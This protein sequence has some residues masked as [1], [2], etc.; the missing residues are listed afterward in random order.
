LKIATVVV[1]GSLL[2]STFAAASLTVTPGLTV[3]NACNK[4]IVIAV[5]YRDSRRNWTTASFTSIRAR[6]QKDRVV[7]SDNSVFYYYAES[8]TGK[9][10]RWAGDRNFKVEGKVYPMRK[11]TL[12]FDRPRNRYYLEITCR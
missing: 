9:P 2:P 12:N 11:A 7:S 3:K 10:S 5:H 6:Q 8:T 1:A 4:D